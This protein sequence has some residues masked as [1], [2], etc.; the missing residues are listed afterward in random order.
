MVLA[1]ERYRL[2]RSFQEPVPAEAPVKD[3]GGDRSETQGNLRDWTMEEWLGLACSRRHGVGGCSEAGCFLAALPAT[4]SSEPLAACTV[5]GTVPPLGLC[6]L[7]PIHQ[8]PQAGVSSSQTWCPVVLLIQF[9]IPISFSGEH[10]F[11]FSYLY[12]YCSSGPSRVS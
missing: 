12:I 11:I 5:S 7:P 3:Q 4:A 8:T 1:C 10:H 6:P 9:Y 2:K